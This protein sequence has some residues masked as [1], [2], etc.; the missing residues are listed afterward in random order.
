MCCVYAVLSYTCRMLHSH[1]YCLSQIG[2]KCRKSAEV[3]HATGTSSTDLCLIVTVPDHCNLSSLIS[4]PTG[5]LTMGLEGTGVAV[6]DLRKEARQRPEGE[7]VLPVRCSKRWCMHE[8]L[9]SVSQCRC[10]SEI[11]S[12]ILESRRQW[13]CG[14]AEAALPMARWPARSRTTALTEVNKSHCVKTQSKKNRV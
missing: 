13:L 12:A 4:L 1:C 14:R 7:L 11:T 9:H 8:N 10:I 6:L 2:A 3:L 5:M